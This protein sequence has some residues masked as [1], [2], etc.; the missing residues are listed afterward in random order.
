MIKITIENV[1]Y[2]RVKTPDISLVK[3]LLS[4]V[5]QKAKYNPQTRKSSYVE[6]SESLINSRGILL[7]GYIPRLKKCLSDKQIP[8]EVDN[9]SERLKASNG[10]IIKG[11]TLRDDQARL[12]ESAVKNQRGILVAP[13]G[14]GKTLLAGAIISCFPGKKALFLCDKKSLAY[15]AAEDFREYGLK[16]VTLVGDGTKDV[17]GN[18]VVAIQKSLI[19]LDL[20]YLS[21]MFDIIILD[22]SHHLAAKDSQHASIIRSL[23]APIRIGL[24]ATY[25]SDQRI[26]LIMEGLL[27]PI[28]GELTEEEAK[29]KNIIAD[30]KVIIRK[31]DFD[32]EVIECRNYHN[33]R[34]VGII[35]N[36]GYNKKVVQEAISWIKEG[37]SVL[38]SFIETEHGKYLKSI[39]DELGLKCELLYGDTSMPI[40]EKV[41]SDF[42][43][44]KIMCVIASTIWR[45]GINIPSLDVVINA[46]G[47]KSDI[48]IKQL[49][50]RG[51]R[52]Y[53]G[54]E[55]LYYVDFFNPNHDSFI[56][57]FGFRMCMYFENGWM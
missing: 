13:T 5:Y 7:S 11:K 44:K 3:P 57:H 37:K 43:A 47:G 46:A 51:T 6:H 1:V 10:P 36:R 19:G 45:E 53:E 14:S 39:A 38:I 21:T 23:L 28:I 20:S 42:K 34:K 26:Q 4:V 15:Q 50:G 49:K 32:Q 2:S 52:Q 35:S 31:I 41:K 48:A 8:Y 29:E 22:E 40:R 9:R 27:G 24:T 17:S 55:M 25:P 30:T 12:V 18:I 54:K 56:K 16:N 33:A